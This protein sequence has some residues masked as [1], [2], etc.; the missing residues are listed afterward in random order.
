MDELDL[1]PDRANLSLDSE[2]F[3]GTQGSHGGTP[4]WLVSK[5]KSQSIK[6][7]FIFIGIGNNHLLSFG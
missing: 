5:G 1:P 7:I 4:K 3:K 6:F 2:G